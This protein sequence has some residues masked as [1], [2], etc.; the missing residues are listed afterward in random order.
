MNKKHIIIGPL[1]L[2]LFSTNTFAAVQE[3]EEETM[4]QSSEEAFMEDLQSVAESKNW[5]IDEAL[6]QQQIS[7]EL[8]KIV[9][10]ITTDYPEIF[11]G[12]VLSDEPGHSPSIYIKGEASQAIYD[13]IATS[14]TPIHIVDKQ[15]YS[16]KELEDRQHELTALLLDL[17]YKNFVVFSDFQNSGNMELEITLEEGLPETSTEIT[18]LLP[19]KFHDNI[20]INLSQESV[21][22]FQAEAN[23]SHKSFFQTIYHW[24]LLM[25]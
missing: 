14:T 2:I 16:F 15:P 22:S 11:V 23:E 4:K 24:V 9:K 8:D 6:V 5:T 17:G 7:E 13:L 3:S 20:K 21:A 1:F 25:W 18:L 19:E 12:S 10:K